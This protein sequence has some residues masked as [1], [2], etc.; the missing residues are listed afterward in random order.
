MKRVAC[1]RTHAALVT[2]CASC[3]GCAR[4]IHSGSLCAPDHS[5]TPRFALRQDPIIFSGNVRENLDPFGD[6]SSDA[7]MWAALKQAGL[8]K[9]IRNLPV[10]TVSSITEMT[11]M[12]VLRLNQNAHLLNTTL[13]SS[14][15]IELGS[16]RDV[17][18]VEYAMDELR[19]CFYR[20]VWTLS[21]WK[22][23]PT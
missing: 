2:L 14:L 1:C 17:L 12:K 21:W 8:K 11:A 23:A 10:S 15:S 3:A 5:A 22:A 18:T 20:A 16:H 6:A 13:E 19:T 7:D 4:H 9:T